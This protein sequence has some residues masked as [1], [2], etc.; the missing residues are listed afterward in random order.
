MMDTFGNHN[1]VS[2]I[3]G[4]ELLINP[5]TPRVSYGDMEVI[6]TSESVDEML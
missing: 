2:V 5:F 4:Q 1:L 3:T 6:L